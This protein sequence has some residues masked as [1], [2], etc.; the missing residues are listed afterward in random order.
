MAEYAA[1]QFSPQLV[2]DFHPDFDRELVVQRTHI[3]YSDSEN[4]QVAGKG[5]WRVTLPIVVQSDADRLALIAA[6]GATP[7]TLSDFFGRTET[8][9]MLVAVGGSQRTW[10]QQIWVLVVTFEREG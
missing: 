2:S 3:P 5:N 7:R 9:V 1:V 8:N 6:M 10:M 4:V